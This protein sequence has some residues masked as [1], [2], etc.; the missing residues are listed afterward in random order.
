MQGGME[1]IYDDVPKPLGFMR[2]APVQ[3]ARGSMFGAA[4][5]VRKDYSGEPVVSETELYGE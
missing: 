5:R 3:T 4:Q 2:F 1:S